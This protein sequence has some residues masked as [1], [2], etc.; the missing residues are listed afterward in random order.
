MSARFS[1]Q[2][3]SSALESETSGWLC[4]TACGKPSAQTVIMHNLRA[5]NVQLAEK[6]TPP[7]VLT[8]AGM[9]GHRCLM[10]SHVV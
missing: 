1:I 4:I 6:P 9:S 8:I 3:Q 10:P 5:V 2:A 7:S